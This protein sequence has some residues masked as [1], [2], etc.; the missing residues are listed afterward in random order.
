[1]A[2]SLTIPPE[3]QQDIISH[4]GVPEIVLLRLTC[5]Y[6]YAMIKPPTMP[7][8]VCYETS[9]Y[10]T[11]RNLYACK[12]CLRLLPS[13]SFGDKMIKAKKRKGGAQATERFCVSCGT[14]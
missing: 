1:M 9:P 3:V 12:V 8:L 10:C 13:T 11:S 6:F 14:T 4:L 5:R 2:P 7:D